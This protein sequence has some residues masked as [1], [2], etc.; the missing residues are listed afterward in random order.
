M[1]IRFLAVS[2]RFALGEEGEE[3]TREVVGVVEVEV[4]NRWEK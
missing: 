2:F 4:D 3:C 1:K